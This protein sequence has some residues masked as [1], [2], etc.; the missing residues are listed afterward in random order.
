LDPLAKYLTIFSKQPNLEIK[1]ADGQ[2]SIVDVELGLKFQH[3][4]TS[5]TYRKRAQQKNQAIIRACQNKQRSI[6]TILDLTAGWGLDSFIL[7]SQGQHVV[8][9]E[10]NQL[11]HAIL[12]CSLHALKNTTQGADIGLDLCHA[13]AFEY[14]TSDAAPDRFD[15]I[16]LDPM[17]PAHKSTAKPGKELQILQAMTE[18]LDIEASFQLAREKAAKRVVV[19]RPAKAEC[20]SGIKPDFVHREKTIRFDVYMTTN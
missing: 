19:K 20:L 13:N 6:D 14:L 18:N 4:F 11:L 5:A 1:V 2:V 9:L 7:A 16:Y 3:S 12:S 10:Q 8:M 15:C 17:F